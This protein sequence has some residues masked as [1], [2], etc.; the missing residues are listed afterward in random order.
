MPPTIFARCASRPSK[1]SS[2]CIVSDGFG[3]LIHWLPVG[4]RQG[5]CIVLV[6]IL[7]SSCIIGTIQDIFKMCTNYVQLPCRYRTD[8]I[9]KGYPA[10]PDTPYILLFLSRRSRLKNYRLPKTYLTDN[11]T[12]SPRPTGLPKKLSEGLKSRL[13]LNGISAMLYSIPMMPSIPITE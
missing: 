10:A 7:Y 8:P 4:Y 1:R 6:H 9:C 3:W 11:A 12:S 13:K 5:I 2:I